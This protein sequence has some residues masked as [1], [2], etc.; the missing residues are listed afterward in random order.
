MNIANAKGTVLLFHGYGGEKS[1]MLEKSDIFNNLGYSTLLVDFMGSGKSEGNQT[2]IGYLEAEQVKSSFE[3]IKEKG[4]QH[5]YLFGTSMGA[6]AVMK[7]I[8]DFAI[9]P[10]SIILECPFGSMYKT[11]RARFNI[12]GIPSFPMAEL[13][14]FWGGIQNGFWAFSHNPTTYATK[15]NC[16]TLLLQG[17]VDKKVSLEETQEIFKNIKAKKY[18]KIYKNAGHENYLLTYK[19][20]WIKDVERFIKNSR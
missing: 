7:A 6:V 1:S 14:V 19:Q 3:Y 10:K 18:L 17:G 4:E 9:N 13:L 5:I 8:N 20:E 11:V 16:P 15:I 12:M 2:T